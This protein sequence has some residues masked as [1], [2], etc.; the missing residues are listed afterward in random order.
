MKLS[1]LIKKLNGIKKI[2]PNGQV[3]HGY[4]PE[5]EVSLA[6]EED[7]F[8]FKRY[9]GPVEEILCHKNTVMLLVYGDVYCN[10]DEEVDE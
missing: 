8:P 4:D 10:N 5:V 1:E 7:K 2:M 6:P 3:L 9:F